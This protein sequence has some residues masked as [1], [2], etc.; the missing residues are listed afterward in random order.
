M[1]RYPELLHFRAPAGT[2]TALSQLAESKGTP[3]S[4]IVREAVDELLRRSNPGVSSE[5]AA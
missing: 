5:Q 3:V 4:T 2:A 1:Y